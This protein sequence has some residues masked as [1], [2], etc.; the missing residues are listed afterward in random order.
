MKNIFN[1]FLIS[2]LIFG[3]FALTNLSKINSQL[4][5]DSL[6]LDE[7]SKEAKPLDNQEDDHEDD[8]EDDHED[9]Q[10]DDQE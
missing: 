8:Q 10:E 5:K 2:L 1:C 7:S 3:L 9:D 4:R 6:D